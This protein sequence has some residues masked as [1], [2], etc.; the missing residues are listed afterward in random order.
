MSGLADLLLGPLC[1]PECRRAVGRGWL[2][3]VRTLA[4]VACA[5]FVLS[6]L[7]WWWFTQSNVD[8]SFLP[9]ASLRVGVAGLVGLTLTVALLMTP[10]Q[11][12]GTLAGDRDRQAM[13][14][15]LTTRVNSFEIVRG[16]I[17]GRLSQVFMA[18][19]ATAPF[20][21]LMAALAGYGPL[22]VLTMF[23]LPLGVAFGVAGLTAAMSSVSRRGRDALLGS[24]LLLLILIN[25]PLLYQAL[26]VA[27]L[28]SIWVLGLLNPY[29]PIGPLVGSEV[30]YPAWSCIVLWAVFGV[31]GTLIA[32]ARLRPACL[33]WLGGEGPRKRGQR[34]W[35][36]VP[37][38]GEHPMRWKE[39]YIERGG[40]MGGFSKWAGGLASVFLVLSAGVCGLLI[41]DSLY[42]RQ[43]SKAADDY[44]FLLQSLVSDSSTF[45]SILIQLAIGLR[46]GV[47]IANERERMTWDGLLTSPLEG[48][49][50]V[51]AKLWGSLWALRWLLLSALFAWSIA[52]AVGAFRGPDFVTILATTAAG[53]A[54][55]AALGV[56]TSL[57]TSTTTASMASTIGIWV[58]AW[59]GFTILGWI[60]VAIGA[61][62]VMV[63]WM[64]YSAYFPGASLT[65]AGPWV[66][67]DP[68]TAF[69]IILVAL[70]LAAT[71]FIAS[72]T[73]LRFDRLAGRM[74][75][76]D[77]AV[78]LDQALHGGPLEPVL[79]D[80]DESP[81]A[82]PVEAV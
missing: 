22:P 51:W 27:R 26:P 11:M 66:P 69:L 64:A 33:Q 47:A 74:A 62:V 78:R 42:R 4:A 18:V 2:I 68:G 49:E 25:L 40:S 32:T 56:R 52:F 70:F 82:E 53:S 41:L 50:I 12:A 35:V 65:A 24:Y 39:L 9:Y 44:I 34:R 72:E 79:L 5:A 45:F 6:I 30:V 57:T 38:M 16:R 23:A 77:L 15:L 31:V 29:V 36:R 59:I 61:L 58:A 63:S 21:V 48:R 73:A 8:P 17:A 46:A 80:G 28:P 20:L 10:A 19:L 7:W 71:F 54:F 60:L 1:G 14:L 81:K 75:G 13:G 3:V 55:I 67:V 43:D 37:L 76:G